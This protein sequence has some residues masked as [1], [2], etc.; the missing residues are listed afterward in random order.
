MACAWAGAEL[1]A[2]GTAAVP[3]GQRAWLAPSAPPTH[4]SSPAKSPTVLGREQAT[5]LGLPH[6]LEKGLLMLFSSVL[7]HGSAVSWA[8][9]N[10]RDFKELWL[11]WFSAQRVQ[12]LGALPGG[13]TNN[14]S[15]LLWDNLFW[16]KLL[17]CFGV[18]EAVVLFLIIFISAAP[19]RPYHHQ[20]TIFL[21]VQNVNQ[22]LP[23]RGDDLSMSWRLK[24]GCEG[25]RVQCSKALAHRHPSV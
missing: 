16:T 8:C 3:A 22:C 25:A 14:P 18:L 15:T 7:A 2:E 11:I 5:G 23:Q 24:G 6:K 21:A 13:N 12:A 10:E 19:Q 4:I 17:Y 9:L 1:L 20:G